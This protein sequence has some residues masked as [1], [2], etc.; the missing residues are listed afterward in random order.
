MNYYYYLCFAV[1]LFDFFTL[2]QE[3]GGYE[4][5]TC[6]KLWKKL[7]DTLGGNANSTSAATYT[8]FEN[9]CNSS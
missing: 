2:S 9:S 6:R 5:I 1:D 8:R 3:M 7:H 4:S